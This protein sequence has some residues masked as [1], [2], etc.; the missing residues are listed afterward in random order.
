M[1]LSVMS[2][3][4][5]NKIWCNAHDELNS[6]LNQEHPAYPLHPEK[7]RVVF[8]QRLATLYV[9]YVQIFRQLEEVYDQMVHPQKRRVIRDVLDGVMG[10]VLELKNEMVEK[11][12]SEYHYMDDVI[13]DL[14]LTPADI[15]IPIP[16]YFLSER[17]RVLQERGK[18]LSQILKVMGVVERPKPL[19]V[20]P[21][22]FEE[23][24][25]LI[26]VSERAR[27]GRLRAKFMKEIQQDGERQ[28]RAKDRDL[29]SDAI[30]H[31]A[32]R[33]QKVWKGYQQR[34]KTKRDREEE[35]VFLGMV[36]ASDQSQLCSSLLAA[37]ANKAYRW[38]KQAEYEEDFQRAT[39]T[40]ADK[41]REVEGPDMRETM[42]DQIRQW[43][44]ECLDAT[45][46]FPDYPEEEDGGSALIFAD[47]TPHQLCQYP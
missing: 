18:I 29:G 31:A 37:Q 36:L 19:G 27:Q 15:E 22:S 23:A 24:V 46:N 34:K 39:I 11:E 43:F 21:L 9:R 41:L 42:K 28:R 12:F 38:Q 32:L 10:R 8:F 25:K 5:Y 17:S 2:H 45:G 44:I 1:R 13:Q 14:K 30:N 7:D 33:I 47:K 16:R 35:M 20:H 40:I 6:L 3:S 26:Q 4:T